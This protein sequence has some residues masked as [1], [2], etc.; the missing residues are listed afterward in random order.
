L[1]EDVSF[2]DS[3]E[4]SKRATCPGRE[5]EGRIKEGGLTKLNVM[6]M[7]NV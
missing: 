6:A 3:G 2:T 4:L 1:G 5:T 7:D